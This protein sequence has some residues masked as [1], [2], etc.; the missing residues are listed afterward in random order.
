M[1]YGVLNNSKGLTANELLQYLERVIAHG[2]GDSIVYASSNPVIMISCEPACVL[3]ETKEKNINELT[4]SSQLRH[5]E[6]VYGRETTTNGKLRWSGVYSG[7]HI[8]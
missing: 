3:M 1:F 4:N 2:D 7:G 6:E 5:E 8:E